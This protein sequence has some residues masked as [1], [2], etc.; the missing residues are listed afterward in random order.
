M[1][2]VAGLHPDGAAAVALVGL[3]LQQ[4]WRRG[5]QQPALLQQTLWKQGAAESD[6]SPPRSHQGGLAVSHWLLMDLRVLNMRL[7]LLSEEAG[8]LLEGDSA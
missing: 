8:W 3:K 1:A 2:A 4:S 5:E 7:E 6:V